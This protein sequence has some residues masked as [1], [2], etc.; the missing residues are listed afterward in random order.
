MLTYTNVFPLWNPSTQ[1]FPQQMTI[2]FQRVVHLQ[3]PSKWCFL[4]PLTVGVFEYIVYFSNVLAFAPM[5]NL[6]LQYHKKFNIYYKIKN[7]LYH[8]MIQNIPNQHFSRTSSSSPYCLLPDYI[9]VDI[10]QTS[11]LQFLNNIPSS[12]KF[13]KHIS[14]K[15]HI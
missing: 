14:I 7:K 13:I 8:I 2:Y 12:L 6:H 3:T 9:C 10:Y 15:E 11:Y 1:N 4:N 5:H